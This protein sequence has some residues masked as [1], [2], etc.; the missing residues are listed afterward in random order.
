MKNVIAKVT[1]Q[2]WEMNRLV[3]ELARALGIPRDASGAT[4]QL[5]ALLNEMSDRLA[6]AAPAN[7]RVEI[8]RTT[9]AP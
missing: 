5:I 6:L 3:R 9:G 2:N 4:D 7:H 8:R 1:A